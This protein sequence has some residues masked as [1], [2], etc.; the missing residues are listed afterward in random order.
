G[1]VLVLEKGPDGGHGVGRVGDGK[2][3]RYGLGK[4]LF[5]LADGKEI[6]RSPTLNRLK[7]ELKRTR[8]PRPRKE[9]VNFAVNNEGRH[10]PRA[11][12]SHT[13]PGTFLGKITDGNYWYLRAP[14]TR[15]T[16]EGYAN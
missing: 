1:E 14:P 2:G 11:F 7:A 6:A 15:V 8:P 9:L 12:A 5:V 16:S 10:F 4:G 3:K 13:R